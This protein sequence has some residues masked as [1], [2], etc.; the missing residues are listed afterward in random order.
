[1]LAKWLIEGAK[2]LLDEVW[3]CDCLLVRPEQLFLR[4]YPRGQDPS[5]FTMMM[6]KLMSDI[7][8]KTSIFNESNNVLR[9]CFSGQ[10][11]WNV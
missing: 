5:V 3:V 7:I 2:R 9:T 6:R 8:L 1:M 11:S 4:K 10:W